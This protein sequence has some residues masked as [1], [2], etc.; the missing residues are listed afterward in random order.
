MQIKITTDTSAPPTKLHALFPPII[1]DYTAVGNGQQ[2]AKNP[3][4]SDEEIDYFKTNGNNATIFIHGYNVARGQFP[5]QV[6]NAQITPIVI[7][8]SA[9][10]LNNGT[11]LYYKLTVNPLLFHAL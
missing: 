10:P 4:L 11:N 7:E 8:S 3:V 6:I 9:G 1:K 2:D 5:S